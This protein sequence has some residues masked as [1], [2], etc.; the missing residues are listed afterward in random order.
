ME[1]MRNNFS[2]KY[3]GKRPVEKPRHRRVD[4]I[5]NLR[6]RREKYIKM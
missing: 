5:K 3:E 2:L 1:E 4:N 6:W